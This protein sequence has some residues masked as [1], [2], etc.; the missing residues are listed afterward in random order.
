MVVSTEQEIPMTH[1]SPKRRRGGRVKCYAPAVTLQA[2]LSMLLLLSTIFSSYNTVH[3]T[4]QAYS[5]SSAPRKP[6]HKRYPPL[7]FQEFEF[8]PNGVCV[9]PQ[10][11]VEYSHDS[12]TTVAQKYFTMRNVPGDGDCMFLAVALAA[13]T[14]MGLGANDALL[15][16]ISRETRSIVAQILSSDGN[17][18]ISP[19]QVVEASK[20]LQSAVRG[21]PSINTEEDYLEALRKEGREG[22]LYGGGPEL[23]VLANVLRRPISIYEV[24]KPRLK[25]LTEAPNDDIAKIPSNRIGD[26]ATFFPILCK[27]SFGEGIFEDPC[28]TSIPNSAVLSNV[29]PGAYSWRLNILVLTVSP[30]EKHAC[31]LLPRQILE[32]VNSNDN[33][34]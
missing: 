10:Y 25:R 5:G 29:Q 15:R 19:G 28:L 4:T 23:A 16:A 27:G 7:T 20:L 1:H 3:Y 34:L 9:F 6:E 24:D 21:E 18:Y 31:V 13:A 22:G 30:G 33:K 12:E 26:D 32:D 2:M 14:S 8:A 17:L 11:F